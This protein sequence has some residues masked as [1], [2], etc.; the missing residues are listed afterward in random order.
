MDF[1]LRLIGIVQFDSSHFVFGCLTVLVLDDLWFCFRLFCCCGWLFSCVWLVGVVGCWFAGLLAGLIVHYYFWAF[2][3]ALI[4]VLRSLVVTGMV[5]VR[6]SCWANCF[7]GQ[8]GL[9]L[10]NSVAWICLL[11]FDLGVAG[12]L[13]FCFDLCIMVGRSDVAGVVWVLW[14]ACGLLLTLVALAVA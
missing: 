14:V 1:A 10:L 8:F 2:G 4:W 5:F 7:A 11:A 12:E 9:V 3:F 13:C 6:F